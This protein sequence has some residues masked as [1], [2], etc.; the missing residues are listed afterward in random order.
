MWEWMTHGLTGICVAMLHQGEVVPN[1]GH[2]AGNDLNWLYKV[3]DA[4]ALGE[5]E[6]GGFLEGNQE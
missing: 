5:K 3:N 1:Q 6:R 2:S 4:C